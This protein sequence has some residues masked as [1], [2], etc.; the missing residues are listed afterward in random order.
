VKD[1]VAVA[2]FL[3]MNQISRD[4]AFAA[5]YLFLTAC[6]DQKDI[7]LDL[8]ETASMHAREDAIRILNKYALVTR[9]PA[10][11][12]LN[13]HRLVHQALRKR[14]Q[15]QGQLVEWTRRTITQLLQVFPD[16]D[17]SNRSK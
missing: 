1:P 7:S 16:D 5:D 12:A 8:L 14:L 3:S 11:S 13:V 15:V 10:K 17:H 2:L 6:V 9:R 4:H